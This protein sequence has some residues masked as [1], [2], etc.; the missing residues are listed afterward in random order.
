V[1]T[2]IDTNVIVALWDA[3]SKTTQA[4]LNALE[5]AFRRGNLIVA[6]PVFAELVAAP[7]RTESFV[8]RFFEDAGIAVDWHLTEAIWRSA[9]A[10]SQAY[11][12]RRRGQRDSRVRRILA[13][14]LIGAHAAAN[15]YRLLTADEHIYRAA[16]PSL[17][18]DTL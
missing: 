17:Q 5:A 4:A 16:F 7:G 2:A 18:I 8:D 13:D 14:F 6:A 9:G 3:D 11:A 12:E 1:I 15:G 10:A